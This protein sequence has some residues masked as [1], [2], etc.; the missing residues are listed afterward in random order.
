MFTHKVCQE[1]SLMTC[2]EFRDKVGFR[3][4][5]MNTNF[6]KGTNYLCLKE[7]VHTDVVNVSNGPDTLSLERCACG[8]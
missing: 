2:L 6:Y 3:G 7:D 8:T 4:A 5:Y 1:C